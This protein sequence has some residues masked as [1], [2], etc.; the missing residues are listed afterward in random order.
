MTPVF[1]GY[2]QRD[3]QVSGKA[4]KHQYPPAG[5]PEDCDL[6]EGWI[7]DPSL[8]DSAGC[9]LSAIAD[10]SITTP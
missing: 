8:L 7:V 6:V 9:W 2:F 5:I 1:P 3:G 4:A 10:K